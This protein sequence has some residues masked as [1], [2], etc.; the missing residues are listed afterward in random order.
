M[1]ENLDLRFPNAEDREIK[2]F[3]RI[4]LQLKL[5]NNNYDLLDLIF[6]DG[7]SDEWPIARISFMGTY[8]KELYVDRN[9]GWFLENNGSGLHFPRVIFINL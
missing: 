9:Y 6:W 2:N 5:D 3:I 8:L 4:H 1:L 7:D